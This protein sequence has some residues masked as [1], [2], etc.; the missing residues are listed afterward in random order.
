MPR[1]HSLEGGY[2]MKRI[3]QWTIGAG[4]A[5]A[6]LA[7]CGAVGDGGGQ[8]LDFSPTAGAHCDLKP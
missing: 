4:L 8:Q 1:A 2:A 6:L 5:I 3:W 7:A